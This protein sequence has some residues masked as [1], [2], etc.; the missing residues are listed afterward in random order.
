VKAGMK[1]DVI[2]LDLK[3]CLQKITNAPLVFDWKILKI[4]YSLKQ[5]SK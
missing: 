3:F 4:K 2:V 5:A 1:M